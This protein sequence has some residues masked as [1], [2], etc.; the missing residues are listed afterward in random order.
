[1]VGRRRPVSWADRLGLQAHEC[2]AIV[3]AGGKSTILKRLGV[4][5][6]GSG[7]RAILTTT[8][9]MATT[10]IGERAIWSVDPDDLTAAVEPRSALF[11]A[12]RI[13]GHKV[14]GVGVSDA[15]RIFAE[16][17]VE[18]LVV[19]ADGARRRSF[20][21]PADHE[22]AIPSSATTVVVVVGIDA[23]GHPASEVA[24]RPEIVERLARVSP[25]APLTVEHVASVLL[26]DQGG[27]KGIPP[28]A[29]VV[30]GISKVEHAHRMAVRE[31]TEALGSHPRVDRVAEFERTG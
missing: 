4:E 24:H 23:V 2:V 8:T 30:M 26:H 1:M 12:R 28:T 6:E 3:G 27:L 15:D 10:Q 7:R 19:E 5:A 13:E 25:T 20:K 16:T 9:H 14:V 18:W 17:D 11:V 21:A 22:P 29:R 31:L